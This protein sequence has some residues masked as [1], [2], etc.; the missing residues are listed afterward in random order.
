MKV[1]L[2]KTN[3]EWSTLSAIEQQQ[4]S[5]IGDA[6][7][8]PT[9]GKPFYVDCPNRNVKTTPITE[10]L[11]DGKFRTENSIYKVEKL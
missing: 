2:T 8:M 10:I 4:A 5:V 11:P 9:V 3:D 7:F 1:K 6:P